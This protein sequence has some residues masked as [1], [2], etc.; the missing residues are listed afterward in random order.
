MST[1]EDTKADGAQHSDSTISIERAQPPTGSTV[2]AARYPTLAR[3]LARRKQFAFPSDTH[4]FHLAVALCDLL[5]SAE[6]PVHIENGTVC[7][8]ACLLSACAN[9]E[10]EHTKFAT[11]DFRIAQSEADRTRSLLW[12]AGPEA[13]RLRCV[14]NELRFLMKQSKITLEQTSGVRAALRD[15]EDTDRYV[16]WLRRAVE[17]Q[18]LSQHALGTECKTLLFATD[19]ASALPAGEELMERLVRGATDTPTTQSFRFGVDIAD[20]FR[21]AVPLACLL[22]QTYDLELCTEIVRTAFVET[23]SPEEVEKIA[24][25]IEEKWDFI[26]MLSRQ[27]VGGEG[28]SLWRALRAPAIESSLLCS[29]LPVKSKSP[30]KVFYV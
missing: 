16:R 9:L 22:Q 7:V 10:L 15:A 23:K 25:D 19:A 14:Q 27:L 12:D 29:V 28:S 24:V 6:A 20:A 1:E 30:S 8:T 5:C 13:M 4:A 11:D 17:V 2:L 26:D 18:Q 21:S 3:L